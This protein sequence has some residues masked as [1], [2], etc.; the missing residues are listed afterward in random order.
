MKLCTT[1]S[2]NRMKN[3]S[4]N[5]LDGFLIETRLKNSPWKFKLSFWTNAGDFCL[6]ST[7][8]C[9]DPHQVQKT[10]S[11]LGQ[12]LKR[13]WKSSINTPVYPYFFDDKALKGSQFENLTP[14]CG[15]FKHRG[16][17]WFS[18]HGSI[19]LWP[20]ITQCLLCQTEHSCR[21]LW[22]IVQR[23]FYMQFFYFCF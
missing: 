1:F 5:V 22:N 4:L 12:A 17:F 6:F 20:H 2:L 11:E 21:V 10:R 19:Q 14:C 8:S 15:A 7:V 3:I 9:A 16:R 23:C 13:G 18:L